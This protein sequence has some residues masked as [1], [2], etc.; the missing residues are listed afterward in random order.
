MWQMSIPRRLL[1]EPPRCAARGG[2]SAVL[3]ST[4]C[5]AL[6]KPDSLEVHFMLRRYITYAGGTPWT[7]TVLN[8]QCAFCTS[9]FFLF[10]IVKHFIVCWFKGIVALSGEIQGGQ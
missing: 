9:M 7:S 3:T 2:I 8:F 10:L 6:H 4:A 1:S 5:V